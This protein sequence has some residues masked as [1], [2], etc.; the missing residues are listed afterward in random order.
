[1][2][3]SGRRS[4]LVRTLH[5]RDLLIARLTEERDEAL[6][7]HRDGQAMTTP[8]SVQREIPRNVAVAVLVVAQMYE[9]AAMENVVRKGSDIKEYARL[10][11]LTHE[12]RVSLSMS[13]EELEVLEAEATAEY[14]FLST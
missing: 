3:Y 8:R 7:K 5:E 10:V 6:R 14:E 13:D 4:E 1:M 9:N 12:L 11:N 2:E